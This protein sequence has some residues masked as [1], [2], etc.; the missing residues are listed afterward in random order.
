VKLPAKNS[1]TLTEAEQAEAAAG[2]AGKP[3][4]G[5]V[6]TAAVI[7]NLDFN[8]VLAAFQDDP[9]LGCPSVLG[10]VKEEL[11]D[12]LEKNYLDFIP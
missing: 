6:E 11:A 4:R 3:E 12:R 10:N 8:A 1:Q 2:C 7:H 9:G 5:R